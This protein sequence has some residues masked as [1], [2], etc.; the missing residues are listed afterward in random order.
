MLHLCFMAGK[1][2]II[3]VTPEDHKAAS[4]VTLPDDDSEPGA[5]YN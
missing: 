3:F 2:I 4:T 5:L 1:D